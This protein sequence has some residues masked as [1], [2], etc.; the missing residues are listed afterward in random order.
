[1]TISEWISE[2]STKFSAS[3]IDSARLDALILLEYVLHT[4]RATLLAHPETPLPATTLVKL[5]VARAQRLDGIPIAYILHKKEFYGREYIVNEHVLIPRPDTEDMI[6]MVK[7]I[8]FDAPRILDIGTGSGCIAISLSLEIPHSRVT[9]T[10]VSDE[11]LKIAKLNAK[12]L[13]AQITFKL[14]DLFAGLNGK[15]FDIV[16]AN[17]PYVPDE[18]ITSPEITKEP[19]LALFSGADGLNHYRQFFTNIGEIKP[20][21]SLVEALESQHTAIEELALSAGYIIHQK[22]GLVLA[23]RAS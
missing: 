16:C 14:T 4:S 15:K 7:A 17:L 18:L 9:A 2:T 1:M 5:N 23:F 12:S 19:A 8:G 3:S 20:V 11:A 13:G 22:Q 6:D 21:Y 10:D